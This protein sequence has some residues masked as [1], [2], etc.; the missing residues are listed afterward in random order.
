MNIP[1]DL[2]CLKGFRYPREIIA[3]VVWVYHR[4]AMSTADFE[5]LLAE[6]SYD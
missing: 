4:F 3:H 5:D 1:I 6:K 2:P